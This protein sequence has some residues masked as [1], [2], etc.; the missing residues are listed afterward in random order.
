MSLPEELHNA[1]AEL[2]GLKSQKWSYIQ[3]QTKK[4][5]TKKMSFD[6]SKEKGERWELLE[7]NGR[8]ASEQEKQ[9]FVDKKNGKV[10]SSSKDSPLSI[11]MPEIT[12]LIDTS[13]LLV[14]KDTDNQTVYQFTPKIDQPL[15]KG[16]MKH[17]EGEIYFNK[18]AGFIEK[19]TVINTESFTP[20]PSVTIKKLYA[21]IL[22]Q[23]L[24]DNDRVVIT[25]T[26]MMAKGKKLFV[27]SIDEEMTSQFS[28]HKL[29][30]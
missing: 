22:L 30:S 20:F 5:E 19:I 12:S 9:H 8:A 6:P 16:V 21:H 3:T 2:E 1:L 25:E 7:L 4:K 18:Q 13:T 10:S 23:K 28:E 26:E 17:L 14:I 27:S 15:L 24:P 29:V 11:A